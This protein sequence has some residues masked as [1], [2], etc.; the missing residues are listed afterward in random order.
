MGRLARFIHFYTDNDLGDSDD[1]YPVNKV[2]G[3]SPLTLTNA[4]AKKLKSLVQFGKV[5]V[6]DGVITCN[7]GTLSVVDGE[8]VTTGT[9]EE[10]MVTGENLFDKD[11]A[12]FVNGSLISADGTISANAS[13]AYC[14]DYMLVAPSTAYSFSGD[15]IFGP[16]SIYNSVA[17][18]DA[19]KTFISRFVPSAGRTPA[20]FTTPNNCYYI[21][22]NAANNSNRDGS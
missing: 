6:S 5:S 19:S 1:K 7:N 13:Y 4:L 8:I 22:F 12:T 17:F 20:Q 10:V 11:T 16:S 18:Y 15:G 14:S 3:T 21:R 9:A 2:F